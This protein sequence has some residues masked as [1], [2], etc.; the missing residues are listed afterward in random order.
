MTDNTPKRALVTGGSGELGAAICRRLAQDGHHVFVHARR[1]TQAAAKLAA[2]ITAAGGRAE[3]LTFDITD[4]QETERVLESA[5]QAGPIQILVNNAGI[6]DDAPFPGM[7]SG[8]WHG[9]LDVSVN[10]FFNVTRPL[11][12]PMIRSRWGR[13]VNTSSISALIGNR[14]QVNYAASKAALNG[15]TKALALEVASRGITVNAI[16]P[17]II[18]TSMSE[19]TF[20]PEAIARLVPMKR[21]GT[22]Q[23]VAG[24]VAYL[25]SDEAGYLT[26]QII[27]ISG[28]MA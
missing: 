2:E 10:G 27:S 1:K 4:A 16:A 21:A 12:M 24:L 19:K 26:S 5:L 11:I 6:H 20:D 15:A 28:G 3:T 9:V 13:I 17:G 23:E 7:T 18:A 22:P 14:G 25:V 8:Q